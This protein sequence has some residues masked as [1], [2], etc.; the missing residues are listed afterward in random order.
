MIDIYELMDIAAEY[1][2]KNLP[3]NLY[4]DDW[5]WGTNCFQFRLYKA[6]IINDQGSDPYRF[7]Y[8]E[9]DELYGTAEEQ[10]ADW[11]ERFGH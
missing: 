7:C 1:L 3:E 6:D 4:A 10:L 8:D 2:K 11:L 5:S 9:D